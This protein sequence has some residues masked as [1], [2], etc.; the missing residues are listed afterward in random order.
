[1]AAYNHFKEVGPYSSELRGDGAPGL[2]RE[3]A[4]VF[5][6]SGQEPGSKMHGLELSKQALNVGKVQTCSYS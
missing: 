2:Q 3:V 5:V 6:E 1:M 4:T